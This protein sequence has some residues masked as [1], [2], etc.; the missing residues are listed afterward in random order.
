[1]CS[2][3]E[4]PS[5]ETSGIV[6]YSVSRKHGFLR[7]YCL[8][9][10]SQLGSQYIVGDSL[11]AEVERHR[12]Q[13]QHLQAEAPPCPSPARHA[14]TGHPT[15]SRPRLRPTPSLES[16]SCHVLPYLVSQALGLAYQGSCVSTGSGHLDE[17]RFDSRQLSP[18][19]TIGMGIRWYDPKDPYCPYPPSLIHIEDLCDS[20]MWSHRD[21][22]QKTKFRAGLEWKA[23]TS[24]H[25]AV[26]YV[27]EFAK[28][29]P[30]FRGLRQNDQI[31]LLKTGLMEVVLVRMSRCF[32][33]ENS[34]VFF[35]GKFGCGDLMVAVFDFA[36]SM[37]ALRLTEQ[38]M[39]LFSSL[40]LTVHSVFP[41]LYKE[42]FTSNLPSV[43]SL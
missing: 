6:T 11:R 30:G 34:T 23:I 8:C 9:P 40:L 37:C 1:M 4:S 43:D 26:Q 38:Q 29:I 18:D 27:V 39:A 20:I 32:N 31:T 24:Q 3:R 12:Q 25:C 10:Y 35:D 2:G 21:T 33:T 41:P 14:V 5:R 22:S 19:Q 7:I 13:Q 36:H 42:L 15:C 16:Q 17:R 28:C